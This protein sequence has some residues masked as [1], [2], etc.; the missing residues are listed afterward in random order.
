[1]QVDSF[2]F[3]PR[4]FRAGY[5]LAP[6]DEAPVF[7]T[8]DRRLADATVTLLSSA[9]LYEPATQSSF[10]LDR[11][12]A[13]PRWGDPTYRMIDHAAAPLAMAHLHVNNTDILADHDVALPRRSLDRLV[14]AGRVGA[15]S[16]AHV[17]VMGYQ[18]DLEVWR[19]HTAPEIA[20]RCREMGTDG[21]V[22]A[23][24]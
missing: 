17:S 16:T 10:D 1:M 20:A 22:L 21:V 3:L 2:R 13:E 11:E 7:A 12:R 4:S 5:E 14:A 19:A 9:G 18:G 6:T 24:V 15:A 23:P 8:F